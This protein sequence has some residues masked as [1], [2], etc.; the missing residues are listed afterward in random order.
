MIEPNGGVERLGLARERA[1]AILDPGTERLDGVSDLLKHGRKRIQRGLCR[2][3]RHAQPCGQLPGRRTLASLPQIGGNDRRHIPMMELVIRAG[4]LAM[5]LCLEAVA[6]PRPKS[7]T[8][9]FSHLPR[10]AEAG[11][12]CIDPVRVQ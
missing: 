12:R 10:L 4:R 5:R 6:C 11:D 8:G 3:T 7:Q 2:P 9:G 1:G